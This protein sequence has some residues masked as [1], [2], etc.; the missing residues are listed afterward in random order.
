MK[1][2][3][4]KNLTNE[5]NMGPARWLSMASCIHRI[6]PLF[7]LIAVLPDSIRLQCVTFFLCWMYLL[8][9]EKSGCFL[10]FKVSQ[11]HCVLKSLFTHAFNKN[12]GNTPLT[13][14]NQHSIEPLAGLQSTGNPAEFFHSYFFLFWKIIV[15]VYFLL[16]H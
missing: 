2:I 10:F 9:P 4:S 5:W 6:R 11:T 16:Y 15:H 7:L 13:Y 14:W 12:F 8:L 3:W 1:Y